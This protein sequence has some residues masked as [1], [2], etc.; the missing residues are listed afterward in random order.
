M[1]SCKTVERLYDA[2]PLRAFRDWLIRVHME[3]CPRCQAR[4][5]SLDEAKSLIVGPGEVGGTEALWHRIAG[6]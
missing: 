3:R 4:L 6:E 1:A 5:L 2:L